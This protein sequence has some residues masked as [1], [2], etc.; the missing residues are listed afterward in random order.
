MRAF[1]TNSRKT[2]SFLL[3]Q[4]VGCSIV[5]CAEHGV[6]LAVCIFFVVCGLTRVQIV[7]VCLLPPLWVFLRV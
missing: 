1:S 2:R 4:L 6:L 3:L 7:V 5:F